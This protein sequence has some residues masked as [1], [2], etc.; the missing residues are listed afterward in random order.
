[1][2]WVVPRARSAPLRQSREAPLGRRGRCAGALG[3]GLALGLRREERGEV[4]GGDLGRGGG[5]GDVGAVGD[6]VAGVGPARAALW[7]W[8][9][10][11]QARVRRTM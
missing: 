10:R 2:K 11:R 4:K 5:G 8:R 3:G 7:R 6:R 9:E 1:M